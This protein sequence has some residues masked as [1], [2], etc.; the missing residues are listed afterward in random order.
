M[1]SLLLA[2]AST[3]HQIRTQ[4]SRGINIFVEETRLV[5][6]SKVEHSDFLRD[7]YIHRLKESKLSYEL[8]YIVHASRQPLSSLATCRPT[9]LQKDGR[10]LTKFDEIIL[11]NILSKEIIP[12]RDG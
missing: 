10:K 11:C 12:W 8:N 6:A 3:V 5:F 4:C 1:I 2:D 7:H 9:I